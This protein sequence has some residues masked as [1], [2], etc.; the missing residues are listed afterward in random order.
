MLQTETSKEKQ[1]LN[2]FDIDFTKYLNNLASTRKKPIVLSVDMNTSH[3]AEQ[4]FSDKYASFYPGYTG[5]EE[6]AM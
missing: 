6:S 5:N 4:L 1:K 3:R 2:Q